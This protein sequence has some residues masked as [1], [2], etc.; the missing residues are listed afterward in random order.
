M[1]CHP[2]PGDGISFKQEME[3]QAEWA[4]WNRAAKQPNSPFPV[5]SLFRHPGI[6]I[7]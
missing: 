4:A 7:G 3:K 2:V 5:Q 6:E 1:L